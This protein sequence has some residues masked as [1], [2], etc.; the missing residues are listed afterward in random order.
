MRLA[1]GLLVLC[2]LPAWAGDVLPAAEAAGWLQ[3]MADASR[4]LPYEG[5]FVMQQGDRMQTLQVENRPGGAG[6]GGRLVMLD[7]QPREVRCAAGESVALARGSHGERFEKRLG[8][9]Y[10]PDLLPEDAGALT[11]WYQVRLGEA[12]R[13]GGQD[14]RE[15]EL[16]PRDRY[17]W[18][19]V[20]CADLASG[21]P[22]RAVMVNDKGQ[23]LMQY[24]FVNIRQ[25]VSG[26]AAEVMPAVAA[27]GD[28]RPMESGSVAVRHLPPGF[29]RVAA[30]RR[31]L[32]NRA[33]E[34]EHW[35]FSDGLAHI[36]LFVEPAP[37]RGSL[38]IRG[39]SPR[40]MLNL[41]SRKVGD[42]Q[43][44]VL[45]EAPWPAVEFIAMGLGSK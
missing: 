21:L 32:P 23:P 14:C 20:I 30:T 22:L 40:G 37:P 26:R 27:A 44:T 38:S 18:G 1:A 13:V 29:T 12:A 16:V 2:G 17:R 15:V 43:V 19:H 24:S 35:V 42:R 36:S 28:L 5:I 6:K 25:G 41:L 11:N 3:R 34:V 31:T 39:E 33:G 4:K 10:F 8:N 7:G 9:R 45:G